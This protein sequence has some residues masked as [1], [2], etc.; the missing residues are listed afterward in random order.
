MK[1]KDLIAELKKYDQELD[2]I[3]WTEDFEDN[4]NISYLEADRLNDEELIINVN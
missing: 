3:V 1:V 4:Y 2:V